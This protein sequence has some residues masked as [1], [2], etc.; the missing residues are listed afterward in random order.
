MELLKIFLFFAPPKSKLSDLINMETDV[1]PVIDYESRH[2]IVKVAVYQSGSAGNFDNVM[3]KFIV[4]NRTDASLNFSLLPLSRGGG[5][6][7][8]GG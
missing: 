8:G 6:G 4:K 3:T 2:N 5:G 7:G 1:S